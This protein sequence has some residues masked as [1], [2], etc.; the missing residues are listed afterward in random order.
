MTVTEVADLT[1][2][3]AGR[4]CSP[5]QVRYLLI[6]GGL[7]TDVQ[8]RT[9]GSTRLYSVIDVALMRLALRIEREGGSPS[10]ARRCV[11]LSSAL[12]GGVHETA[13]SNLE[14]GG[15][16]GF[17]NPRRARFARTGP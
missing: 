1:S 9:H 6:G 15:A 10:I 4:P 13:D 7:G 17:G 16:V 5:R 14:G 3:L 2:R 11:D 12:C 8:R